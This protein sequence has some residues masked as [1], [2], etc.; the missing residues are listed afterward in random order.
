VD[1]AV[2]FDNL[3]SITGGDAAMEAELFHVFLDSSRTCLAALQ[4]SCAAGDETAWKKEAH[5]F[6]GICFNLGA[7]P[8]G[9]LC[10]TAQDDYRATPDEKKVMLAAMEQELA[11]VRQAIETALGSATPKI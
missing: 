9:Q 7:G 11:Q 3:R 10:K 8:L 1:S 4:A 2:N 5:A 6:K